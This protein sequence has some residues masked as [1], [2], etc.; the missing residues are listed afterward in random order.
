M[1][2]ADHKRRL[3]KANIELGKE[4]W[5]IHSSLA[6]YRI[7]GLNIK[8]IPTAKTFFS[9]VQAQSLAT[10]ALGLRKVFEREGHYGLC[11]VDG[12]YQLAKHVQIQ[13][14]GVAKTFVEK[15]GVRASADW[16]HDVDEVFSRRRSWLKRHMHDIGSVRNTRLA[17]LQQDAP[18]GVL[19]S[20]AGFEELLVFAFDFHSFVNEAFFVVIAHPILDDKRVESSLLSLLRSLEVTEPVSQFKDS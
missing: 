17:H 19:P 6:I 20:I 18:A 2:M 9:V 12:V 3:D 11:S 13:D 15:Y 14:N 16:I 8:A 5:M 10:V 4:L 1:T 7:I